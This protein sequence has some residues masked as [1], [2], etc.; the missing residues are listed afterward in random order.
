MRNAVRRSTISDVESQVP[1]DGPKASTSLFSGTGVLFV[2]R[3]IVAA[4]G[5]VG[6][7]LIVRSLS[8]SEWGAFSLIFNVLGLL[9]LVADFQTSRIVVREVLEAGDDLD[10]L[11]G[12]FVAFR[13]ALGGAMYVIAIAFVVIGGY[14]H[15]IVEGVIL[16]GLSFFIST[17]AW[18]LITVCQARLW[19]R[20]IAV[21]MVVGQTVQLVLI[22][23]L[24]VGHSHSLLQF[25]VP[26]VIFDVVTL[27]WMILA[28]KKVVRVRP[29]IQLDRWWHWMKDAAPLAVGST[30]GTAYFR[31][32]GIMLS[33]LDNVPAVGVYQIGYKFSDVL[34]FMAPA[35]LG[36]VLPQLIRAWPSHFADFR[37]TFR[38]AFI[39]FFAFGTFATVTF[40][41]LC[42]PTIATLYGSDYAGAARPA[43]LLVIGQ[44]LNLFTQLAFVTLVAAHRRKL[45]PIATFAGLVVNVTLNFVLIPRYSATGAGISTIITE[46]VVLAILGYAVRDL[47]IRPL[48]WRS[49]AV[50]ATSGCVLLLALFAIRAVA[51]WEVAL[52][53]ALVLY[54]GMLHVL[55]IDGPGGLVAFARSSRFTAS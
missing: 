47:P 29:H 55:R 19:L 36:A 15:L 53:A 13:V 32:D 52:L 24:F 16:G 12:S 27:V 25:V 31:I 46:V 45:Y 2:S 48:P 23:G 1:A 3:L 39:V 44:G 26:F 22:V 40:A 14:G 11:V 38:Q 4:L 5:W 35:L 20:T 8:R 10:S 28:V 33:K 18:A 9:G 50:I 17:A 7:I 30:L 49:I 34:A 42:G 54:P 37:R 6:T 43:R 51:P 41:V 21:S